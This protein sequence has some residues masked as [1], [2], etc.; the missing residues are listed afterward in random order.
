MAS[1]ESSA[2]SSRAL[3][4]PNAETDAAGLSTPVL[5]PSSRRNSSF[6]SS[7]SFSSNSS[8]GSFSF[9][10]SY[11]SLFSPN[12]PLRFSSGI[13]FSWEQIPGIPKNGTPRKLKEFSS[14][15]DLLPLPPAGNSNSLRKNGQNRGEDHHISPKKYNTNESFRKDPF[16]AALVECS[17]DDSIGD[18]WKSSSKVSKTLSDR[19]GFINMYTSCKRTCT[20]SESIV[21]LPRSRAYN[22]L[23]R[24]PT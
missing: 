10:D 11:D 2:Y 23:N 21:Y 18:F 4:E 15:S 12:T 19:F 1:T 6:S 17:K 3:I 24:R 20:V 14:Q 22:M 9:Q 7:P 5:R 16:F 13:P 8:S